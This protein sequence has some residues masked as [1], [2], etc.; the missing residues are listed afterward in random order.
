MIK[1]AAV[2]SKVSVL[3]L[4]I[5]LGIVIL[6]L[7]FIA[8]PHRMSG[9]YMSPSLSDGDLVITSKLTPYETGSIVLYRNA[10]GSL[11]FGRIAA[12]GG[13]TV[14]YLDGGGYT[15][16]G[17]LPYEKEYLDTADAPEED[18]EPVTLGKNQ[19]F[20]INDQ[21]SDQDDSRTAGPVNKKQICGTVVSLF[22][23]RNF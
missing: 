15:V 18:Q 12:T 19:Y 7:L 20:I 13:Q 9:N 2:I 22:R 17:Y 4:V 21:R 1:K 5:K 14:S 6:I 3:K 16:D 23:F 10:S 11:M 8:S